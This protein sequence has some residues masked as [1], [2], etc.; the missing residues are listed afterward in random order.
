MSYTKRDPQAQIYYFGK[1]GSNSNNGKNWNSDRFL[2]IGKGLTTIA[3][4][5]PDPLDRYVLKCNDAGIYVEQVALTSTDTDIDAPNATIKSDLTTGIELNI[6]G[7]ENTIKVHAIRANSSGN[8]VVCNG[9]ATSNVY[10]YID[11]IKNT[12]SGYGLDVING[13]VP[14]CIG[15]LDSLHVGANGEVNLIIDRSS[16]NIQLDDGSTGS[17]IIGRQIAGTITKGSASSVEVEVLNPGTFMGDYS[18]TG[19]IDDPTNLSFTPQS[20]APTTDNATIYYSSSSNNFQFR[21]NGSW[22]TL[23]GGGAGYWD[24]TGTILEPS[25]AGDDVDMGTGEITAAGVTINDATPKLLFADTDDD[26]FSVMTEGDNDLHFTS[27]ESGGHAHYKFFTYDGD[28]TNN[29]SLSIFGVGTSSSTTDAE[30][31]EWHFR[32]T[33]NE[34]ELG[35][36]ASGTG[37]VR[38]LQI[39]TGSNSDQILLSTDGNVSMSG[40]LS[41]TNELS[42]SKQ[43]TWVVDEINVSN[44][45]TDAQLDTAYGSPAT[46]GDGWTT[47][48]NDNGDGNDFYQVASDGT[49][50]WIS[51]F[52]KAV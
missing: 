44:P 11:E 22:E 42:T 25:T 8:A 30:W 49:N 12:G 35:S 41:V 18:I 29:I 34:F 43:I 2:T 40:K 7:G 38:P 45:P 5:T 23:G 52:T 3:A 46:V 47:Y 26:Y 50:W 4:Q 48:I 28:G 39:Y 6:T 17:L 9:D 10:L 33:A 21:E 27:E 51:T 19:S 31:L 24:R 36:R 15:N 14:G 1:V 32:Y 13:Y 16:G 20:S 37:T